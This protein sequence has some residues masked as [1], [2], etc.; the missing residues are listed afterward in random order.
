MEPRDVDPK[1]GPKNRLSN[2]QRLFEG[3]FLGPE[4]LAVYNGQL[5]TGVYDGYILRIE[6]D[7]FVPVAK[8]GKKCGELCV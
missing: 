2:A 3:K 8:F 1:L 6:E 7:D 4:A 5:Y